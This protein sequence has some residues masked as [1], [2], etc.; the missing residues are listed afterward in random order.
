MKTKLLKKIRKQYCVSKTV[1]KDCIVNVNGRVTNR[2]DK[3]LCFAKGSRNI[4]Y[5]RYSN[6]TY[7]LY[8][9]NEYKSSYSITDAPEVMFYCYEYVLVDGELSSNF[10]YNRFEKEVLKRF[11]AA[12]LGDFMK[13]E[14]KKYKTLILKRA[15]KSFIKDIKE[16]R[17]YNKRLK[18]SAKRK[19]TEAIEDIQNN[20][21]RW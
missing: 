10:L 14:L 13:F 7:T 18:E 19:R 2:T 1:N 3:V 15:I 11:Y 21:F 16:E 9:D 4:L 6:L 8:K 12:I 5:G 20:K 17:D